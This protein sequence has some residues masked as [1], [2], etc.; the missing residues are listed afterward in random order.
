[1]S[2]FLRL[3]VFF[4]VFLTPQ[5]AVSLPKN[6]CKEDSKKLCKDAGFLPKKIK[7]CLMSHVNELSQECK[8]HVTKG[9]T[10]AGDTFQSCTEQL[11]KLCKD[12]SLI[13]GGMKKCYESHKSTFRTGA[14]SI[15]T[16]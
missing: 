11:K 8:D 10:S 16:E 1:M 4:L 12:E 15:S 14:K 2:V 9:K 7:D 3:S 13:G 5:L 6:P